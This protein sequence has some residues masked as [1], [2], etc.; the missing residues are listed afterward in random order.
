MLDNELLQAGQRHAIRAVQLFG[1][2]VSG[3]L[4]VRVMLN[5]VLDAM[6]LPGESFHW[7]TRRFRGLTSDVRVVGPVTLDDDESGGSSAKIAKAFR[8]EF[9]ILWRD[10]G[11]AR[12]PCFDNDGDLDGSN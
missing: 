7:D 2:G 9:E 5:G 6:L 3:P 1:L 11:V 4:E 8:S 10:A 12:D